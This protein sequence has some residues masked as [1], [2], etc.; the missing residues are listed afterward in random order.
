[1]KRSVL[2]YMLEDVIKYTHWQYTTSEHSRSQY[3]EQTVDDWF[4]SILLANR[5]LQVYKLLLVLCEN[6]QARGPAEFFPIHFWYEQYTYFIYP[7]K[8][9]ERFAFIHNH[10][11]HDFVTEITPQPDI[12]STYNRIN[13]SFL[14]NNT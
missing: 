8:E 6:I 9:Q 10:H 7:R 14:H 3:T 4:M 11:H 12:I 2:S 1:M 13:P 5:I